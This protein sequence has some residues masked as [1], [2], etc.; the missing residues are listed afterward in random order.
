MPLPDFFGN[1]DVAGYLPSG[2]RILRNPDGSI[3]THR[4]MITN[5]DKDFYVL[6]TIYGGKQLTEDQAVDVVRKH[7]F[8]DPDTGQPFPK[9]KSLEEAEAAEA[10]QHGVL[11][12]I[13]RMLSR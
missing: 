6:P 7:N 11:D 5:F 4:N 10:Q 8:V 12:E 1:P 3:S 13:A 2:R 9:Y